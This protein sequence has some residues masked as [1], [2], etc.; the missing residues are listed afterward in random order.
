MIF[1]FI[2]NLLSGEYYDLFVLEGGQM[3]LGTVVP[4]RGNERVKEVFDVLSP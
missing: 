3:E 4:K 1:S 2:V